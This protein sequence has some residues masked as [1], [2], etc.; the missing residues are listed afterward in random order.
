VRDHPRPRAPRPTA[1]SPLS[2][3]SPRISPRLRNSHWVR[4]PPPPLSPSRLP[5]SPP[6]LRSRPSKAARASP[7]RRISSLLFL[8]AYFSASPKQPLGAETPTATLALSA[9]LFS[10]SSAFET[11]Q[12]RARLAQPPNLLSLIPLRVFLSV[13]ET[14]TGCG[15]PHRHSRPLGCPLL[16]LLCVRDHPRPRAPR[17]TAESP[18]SYSS[19]RIS[20]RLR[21]SHWVRKPPPPL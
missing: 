5:S 16:R 9:A 12:G 20:Q 11:I 6:P 17:P 18:L 8:S 2:Y 19:P 1:E 21:N 7:N 14:A 15:N 4:K 10:A 3:P 13:S